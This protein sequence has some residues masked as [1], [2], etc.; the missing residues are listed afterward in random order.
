MDFFSKC[1]LTISLYRAHFKLKALRDDVTHNEEKVIRGM[2]LL[3]LLSFMLYEAAFKSNKI[4]EIQ[5]FC[6]VKEMCN[7]PDWGKNVSL[8]DDLRR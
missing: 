3:A 5:H 7:I 8:I 6:L 4:S 1:I 2:Q